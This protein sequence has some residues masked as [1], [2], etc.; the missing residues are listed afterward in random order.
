MNILNVALWVD[1]TRPMPNSFNCHAS[2]YE[3]AIKI[4]STGKV[5]RISLDYDLGLGPTGLEI[6][7]WIEKQAIAGTLPK[8]RCSVHSHSIDGKVKIK[9]VLRNA[10]KAWNA[11]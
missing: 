6:A 5:T 8:I 3:E 7:E 9:A 4:L 11:G 1:D 10:C 2:N